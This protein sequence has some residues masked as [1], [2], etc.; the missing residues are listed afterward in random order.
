MFHLSFFAAL[1]AMWDAKETGVALRSLEWDMAHGR[2]IDGA[3][4]PDGHPS[5]YGPIP[6]IATELSGCFGL[7][8]AAY[9]LTFLDAPAVKLESLFINTAGG[10]VPQCIA[11]HL[12]EKN[13]GSLKR[14]TWVGNTRRQGFRTSFPCV[15]SVK[16][17]LTLRTGGSRRKSS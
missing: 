4:E 7:R 5:L 14:F 3:G 13:K 6:K 16:Q 12:I 17:K 11:S 9:T 15:H 2:W 10:Q 8:V 1:S